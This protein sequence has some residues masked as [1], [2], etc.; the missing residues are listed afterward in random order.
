MD[1]NGEV[2]VRDLIPIASASSEGAF[3]DRLSR[4]IFVGDPE[5]EATDEWQFMTAYGDASQ[6][7]DD[8]GIR[9]CRAFLIRRR[10]QSASPREDVILVGRSST[11]DIRVHHGSVSKLH[12]RIHLG[13]GGDV[14]IADATSRNGTFHN[15]EKLEA[16]KQVSLQH[17]DVVVLGSLMLRVLATDRLH[18][19]LSMMRPG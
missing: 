2:W 3:R 17:G 18:R 8:P 13:E 9:N 12:A 6:P 19:I 10:P 5:Q 11:N 4:F 16:G 7:T 1:L 14:A 15:G